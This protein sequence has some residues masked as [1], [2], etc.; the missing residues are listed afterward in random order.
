[1]NR[2]EDS[3]I[4]TLILSTN[5]QNTLILNFMIFIS[6][7][8]ILILILQTYAFYVYLQRSYRE[9]PQDT[10][11]FFGTSGIHIPQKSKA[12]QAAHDL[13]FPNN[14]IVHKDT[15]EEIDLQIGV[16]IP[17]GHFGW[18]TLRSSAHD[19]KILVHAGAIV[20]EYFTGFLRVYLWN[21]SSTDTYLLEKGTSLLQLLIIPC[22][23]GIAKLVHPSQVKWSIENIGLRTGSSGHVPKPGYKDEK[24]D[25]STFHQRSDRKAD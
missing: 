21:L 5:F 20:D 23:Q 24:T 2:T 1:M 25:E 6:I 8:L 7:L 22:H 19:K 4:K 16:Q 12:L 18:I 17:R 14:C 13:F 9:G 11:T 3:E 15:I 10:V